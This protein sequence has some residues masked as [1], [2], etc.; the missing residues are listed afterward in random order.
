M[1]PSYNLFNMIPKQA[2]TEAKEELISLI[3][4]D[5]DT[6]NLSNGKKVK[7]GW[8]KPDTQDKIDTIITQ[9]DAIKNKLS[10]K[11]DNLTEKELQACNKQTRMFYSKITSAILLNNFFLL[12]FFWWI[13]WRYMYYFSNMN[14]EDHLIIISEAKKKA[15]QQEYYLAMALAMDMTTMWTTMTKKEAEAYRQELEL[16]R[17]HQSLKNS[18]H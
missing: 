7:I 9:Y 5:K 12:R 18:Q 16:V 15:Q 13:K 4:D 2:T 10:A 3:N 6:I 14:A 1:Y 17:E 11:E 8:I